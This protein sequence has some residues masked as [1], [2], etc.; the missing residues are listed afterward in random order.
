[1]PDLD[2]KIIGVEPAVHGLTPLLHFKVKITNTPASETIQTVTL[3]AQ[4]QFQSAQRAYNV[5]EQE[6]LLDLFGTP[7]RWGQT[8]RNRLWAHANTM[9]R[10]FSGNTEATL[11]V[12]C[13]YDMNVTATKY[14]YAL[15]KGDVSLLFL[16]SGT[17]FY[18]TPDNRLQVQQVSWDKEC[19]YRMPISLWRG[20]MEHHYP[21]SA[22]L[23][24]QRESFEKLYAYKRR[25]GLATWEQAIERL[26]PQPETEEIPA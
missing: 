19:V 18:T 24:L 1:M 15:E 16:F 4:I 3:H 5:R 8:L 14:F 25:H 23:Y 13:T 11:P 10:T 22:W 9:V 7:D 6:R 20:M 17:V 26:L 21:N 2:F 12:Q